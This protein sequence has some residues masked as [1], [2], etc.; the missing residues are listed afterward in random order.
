MSPAEEPSKTSELL[1]SARSVPA[2]RA[3]HTQQWKLL[4]ISYKI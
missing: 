3:A 1:F 4:Q 2:D